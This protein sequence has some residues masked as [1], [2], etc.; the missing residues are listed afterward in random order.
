M[1]LAS[2]DNIAYSSSQQNTSLLWKFDLA[3]NVKSF[4]AKE[5]IIFVGSA[6]IRC[7]LKLS[8]PN[9]LVI[10][11]LADHW[12]FISLALGRFSPL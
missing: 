12:L 8:A 4:K 3:V 6:A 5:Q 10:V 2:F 9:N 11:W 7:A 1:K